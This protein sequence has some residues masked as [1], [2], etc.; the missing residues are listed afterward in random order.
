MPEKCERCE[1]LELLANAYQDALRNTFLALQIALD[2][3]TSD[4]WRAETRKKLSESPLGAPQKP[5]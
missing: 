4:T 1:Q 5:Q 2:P 3:D